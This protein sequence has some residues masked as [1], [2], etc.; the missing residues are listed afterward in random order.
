MITQ[1]YNSITLVSSP[2]SLCHF[3]LF[4]EKKGTNL[5]IHDTHEKRKP[6]L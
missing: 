2:G 1:T 3:E 6:F 5:S 4:Q